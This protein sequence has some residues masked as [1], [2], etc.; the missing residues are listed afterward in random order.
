MKS[1]SVE[2]TPSR[3]AVSQGSTTMGFIHAASAVSMCC[4]GG[5]GGQARSTDNASC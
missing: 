1:L 3:G 2:A 4:V 5:R